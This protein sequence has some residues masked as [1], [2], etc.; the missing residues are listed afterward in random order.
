MQMHHH[1]GTIAMINYTKCKPI[2]EA[3]STAM[4]ARSA[5]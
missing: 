2:F 5:K 1:E 4:M 3:T